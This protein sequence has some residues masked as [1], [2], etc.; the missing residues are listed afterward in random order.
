MHSYYES[1]LLVTVAIWSRKF[2]H[3]ANVFMDTLVPYIKKRKILNGQRTCDIIQAAVLHN[4]STCTCNMEVK[5][6]TTNVKF[7]SNG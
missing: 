4:R 6:K 5:S 2:S 7:S 3:G 1:M